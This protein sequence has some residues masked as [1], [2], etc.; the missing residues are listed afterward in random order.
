[1][2]RHLTPAPTCL[3]QRKRR[4]SNTTHCNLEHL[5]GGGSRKKIK[6]TTADLLHNYSFGCQIVVKHTHQNYYLETFVTAEV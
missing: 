1:M 2:V 4:Q 6:D 3:D 5:Q